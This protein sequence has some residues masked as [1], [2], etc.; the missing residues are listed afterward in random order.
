MIG[1]QLIATFRSYPSIVTTQPSYSLPV[2]LTCIQQQMSWGVRES[3]LTEDVQPL[4][5]RCK[6][7]RGSLSCVQRRPLDLEEPPSVL[8]RCGPAPTSPSISVIATSA[9]ISF[10]QVG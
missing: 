1:T 9:R 6:L 10:R 3:R 4:L 7:L 2:L 8:R 5:A